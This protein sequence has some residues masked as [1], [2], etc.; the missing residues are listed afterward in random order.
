MMS[1]VQFFWT[2]LDI[3]KTLEQRWT[4]AELL[5]LEEMAIFL[6]QKGESIGKCFITGLMY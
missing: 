6:K 1:N 3:Q 5:S 4:I 2:K